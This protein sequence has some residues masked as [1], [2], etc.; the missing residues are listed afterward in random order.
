[1]PALNNVYNYTLIATDAD[2]NTDDQAVTVTVTDVVEVSSL[3]I[4]N[5]TSSNVAENAA[6]TSATPGLTG[7]P[8]GALTY[9]LGGTDAL[10]F[11]VNASTGVASMIARN[12]E[13]PADAGTDNV[14]DYTLIATDA[15]GNTDSQTVAVTVTDVVEV[16]S[17]TI[18]NLAS[19]SVAENAAYT[20][21]TPSL[22]GTIGTVTYTLGG[23]DAARFTV[24]ASTGVVS[25][26]ARNFESPVDA[27]PDNVYNYT[28][29]ATD[30]DGN[31]DDQAVTVTV[32]DVVEVSTLTI[33]NLTDTS[34]A[35]N[36]AYTS[37]TLSLSGAIGALT[38]S[39][40][41]TD[42][43]LFAVN[44]STGVVSMVARNFESPVDAGTDNVYNYTLIATDADGNTDDQAVAV[45][46]T[47]VV[48][49]SAIVI[50]NLASSSVAENAAYTSSTPSLSGAIGA[51]TYSLS[52]TDALLFTVNASTGVVS[53]VARNFE[54]PADAGANNVYDYTLIATDADGNTDDQAVA[55]TV[56]DVVEV[57]TL[58]ITN[59]TSSNVAEN[60]AYT[61]ST[62]SLSGAIG[63]LT[64]SLSGT[65]AL[66]FTVN[67]STGVV[68]MVARNFEIP[69][70]DGTNNVYNYTL[71]ATD[72]DGNTDDQAVAVTVTD[73]VEVSS[74][75]ITNLTSSNVAENAAYTSSTPSLSGAIG[76]L[77]YSLSG[78][79]ALL[80][81]VNASTGVVSMVARN[82]EIPAD[83]GTNNVYN[84]TLIATDA[85]GN[86]DDQAVAVT[87]TDV[88][89][90][91]TLTITNLAS[92]SVAENAAYTSS[93]PSLSGAIGALTYSLSGTDA[94]LFTV[95]ASTGV[96]SMI[97]RNFEIPADD[98]AN[99]VYDYTLIATDADGNT[100]SQ[101]VAVTVT[102]VVEVSAIVITNLA[103][104][105]VAENAAYTSST[106][107]LTGTPIGTVT[108]SLGRCWTPY[109]SRSTPAPAW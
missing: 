19:S 34:V 88:V 58:T 33:T 18:T 11:T 16:S 99:N 24:N 70:D 60:A 68:S 36:A 14:Y 87:V 79:D 96:V 41:G 31:T 91:S 63:A 1:M 55:V 40:S 107:S 17:L 80:F 27:G 75:T 10:L 109:G 104:S 44:A 69:A 5:L 21:S 48:E 102:D 106:P 29:I 45:T 65:D 4:T 32:T 3:T 7:T 20:S 98:G 67:A 26:V 13:I 81:T 85:D 49:V 71:I 47:D 30:A 101:T 53:M 50:T 108:Y 66:L 6:Y 103:S 76:A 100:D 59:L 93:T 9:S 8:I 86:T 84:Y 25:M 105:S 12:F 43:L 78:T 23:V 74:L 22:T 72:A 94:L 35:E 92:S 54:S 15:D 37:S 46:V 42:A 2:G 90:V 62:P 95:N 77:T 83:D 61:S 82:F 56:T 52:G 28:L 89:E 57:S 51:L 64:Y 39:L 38:Y 97:A 73:V